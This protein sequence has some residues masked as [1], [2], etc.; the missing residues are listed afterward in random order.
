VVDVAKLDGVGV[1]IVKNA[2][3]A[4]PSLFVKNAV[5]LQMGVARVKN[6]Q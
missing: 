3:R 4:Y 2:S 6:A 5:S 1:P